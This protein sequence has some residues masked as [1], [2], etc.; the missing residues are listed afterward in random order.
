MSSFTKDELRLVLVNHG[1]DLPNTSAK[2]EELVALYEEFVA[3]QDKGEFSSDDE[4]SSPKKK[5]PSRSSRRSIGS[6]TKKSKAKEVRK[7]PLFILYNLYITFT[8]RAS[9][10]CSRAY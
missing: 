5:T 6:T 7:S 8:E 2:K 10:S 1:V 4:S 9:L 3:P